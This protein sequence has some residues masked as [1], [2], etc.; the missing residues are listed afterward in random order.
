MKNWSGNKDLGSAGSRKL[1][2]TW[3]KTPNCLLR[4]E[5]KGRL[6][7]GMWRVR[8]CRIGIFSSLDCFPW[9]APCCGCGVSVCGCFCALQVLQV[10]SLSNESL[11]VTNEELHKLQGDSTDG[12]DTGDSWGTLP[13]NVMWQVALI[14]RKNG[15]IKL[16]LWPGNRNTP[17]KARFANRKSLVLAAT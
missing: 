6:N 12:R 3:K 5:G 1:L 8:S 2:Q 17:K 15:K 9:A 13:G 4:R 10:A 7:S 16:H 14:R 11:E